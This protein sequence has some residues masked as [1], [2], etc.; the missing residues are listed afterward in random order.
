MKKLL[1]ILALSFIVISCSDDDNSL[2]PV[3]LSSVNVYVA[4]QKD[5]N[6]TYW[7]N[8]TEITLDNSGFNVSIA[9]KIMVQNNNVYVFGRGDSSYLL[10]KNGIMTNLTEEFQEADYE[11]EFIADMFIDGV[12]EYFIGYLKSTSNPTNYD[13]VYWKNGVKT[14]VLGNC[15]FRHQQSCIKVIDDNVYVLSKNENNDYGIFINTTFN[16]INSGYLPYG[17]VKN[18]NEVYAYGSIID[19]PDVSGFYKNVATSAETNFEQSIRD[20]AFDTSDIYT[21]VLHNDNVQFS[22]RR[23]IKKNNSSFYVTPEGYESH[24]V[25]LKAV[26]GNVYIIVRELTSANFGPN[27]LLINNEEELVLDENPSDLLNSIYI[28]E[29]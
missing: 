5:G 3:N 20:L 10:W 11:V 7:E 22:S 13:L 6:A 14:I 12:D 1:F 21:M 2:E 23:E 4:G 8:N 19:N 15:V 9:D 27:K 28:V 26:N 16:Q 17:I 18:E 25:D 29:D 24:I